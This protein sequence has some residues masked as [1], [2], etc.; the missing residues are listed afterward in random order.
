MMN[1]EPHASSSGKYDLS[2][3]NLAFPFLIAS[4]IAAQSSTGSVSLSIRILGDVTEALKAV[5]I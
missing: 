2:D 5:S 1:A 4:A 3:T